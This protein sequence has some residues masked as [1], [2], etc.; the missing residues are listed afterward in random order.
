MPFEAMFAR[1]VPEEHLHSTQEIAREILKS[2][3]Q[4]QKRYH[5]I[6]PVPMRSPL[7]WA[8][9]YGFM[10]LYRKRNCPV[11]ISVFMSSIRKLMTLHICVP[12]SARNKAKLYRADCLSLYKGRGVPVWIR[13]VLKGLRTYFLLLFSRALSLIGMELSVNSCIGI[14]NCCGAEFFVGL[15]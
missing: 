11:H 8:R 9:W 2:S 1:H 10:N 13:R 3:T 14:S 4:H 6:K 5:D 15:M 7:I 12:R